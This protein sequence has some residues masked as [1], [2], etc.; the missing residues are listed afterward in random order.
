MKTK[1]TIMKTGA[2][3]LWTSLLAVFLITCCPIK[4]Q[5]DTVALSFT[6]AGGFAASPNYT[7]GWAFTLSNTVTLTELG[8]WDRSGTGLND[9]HLVT[10]WTSTGTQAAQTTIPSGTSAPIT[11]GFRYESITPVVLSAGSYTI[12]AFFT[13]SSDTAATLCS[14]VTTAAG[15]T[16][17]GSKATGGNGFPSFDSA[18]YGNG[19]FGPNFQFTTEAVPEPSTWAVGLLTAGLLLCSIWRRRA[20]WVRR[21]IHNC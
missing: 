14:T 18:G 17:D 9:S 1:Q 7:F 15:V 11:D 8:V 16:Y 5:A 21:E 19:Y 12:G 10:L 2:R 13:S 6:D 3:I 20:G 4:T